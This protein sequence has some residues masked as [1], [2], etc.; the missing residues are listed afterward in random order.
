MIWND[1]EVRAALGMGAGRPDIQFT[2][3]STDSRTV[4]R[5]SLFVA[6]KGER[7]DAHGFVNEV[8][9]KGAR[10]AVVQH[11]VAGLGDDF[12]F[13]VV[14]DTLTALGMLGRHRR[15]KLNA[16]LVAVLGSNGKTTTKEILRALLSARYRVHA[17]TGNLNNLIGTPLTLLAAPDDTEVIVAELGTSLPGEVARL[18]EIVEANAAVVTAISQE[19]LEGLGDL[20]G[21]LEEETALLPSLPQDGLAVV[22]DEPPELATAARAKA[23]RVA[24]AGWSD[25]ADADLRAE[26]VDLDAHGHVMFAWQG[27]NVFLPLR[28]KHN[29]RNA[30]VALGIALH[31]G[32]DVNAA[33][34]NLSELKPA[35]M[36]G[37]VREYGNLKVIVDC[38]NSNPASLSAAIDLLASM[39]HQG[40]RVAI[41]G[42]MLEL[43]GES[44]DLHH[45]AADEIAARNFDLVVAT[46]EFVRA[47][48]PH[49]SR[50]GDRLITSVDPLAAAQQVTQRLQGDEL[51]LLKGSRG[52]A[53]E[54][55]LP[56]L[57]LSGVPHPHGEAERPGAR[58][59]R[60]DSRDEAQSAGH[61]RSSTYEARGRVGEWGTRR[62][63]EPLAQACHDE[64]AR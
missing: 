12:V 6:L 63:E 38:Y 21:V 3:I 37:E 15:R 4:E 17:T 57:E 7:F 30:L 28:G 43:G 54:R 8:A 56:A 23:P 60:T 13:Y 64:G 46:G 48:E 19:H 27:R 5:G 14:P 36:R 18:A 25:R 22:A 55:L 47:F 61:S 53:L 41:V 59:P 11:P 20:R 31:F 50:L 29:A 45:T 39:P 44:A 16:R 52:V 42:S 10:G 33:L 58:S 35:K 49:V 32:V 2:G 34:A 51:V 62:Y 1:A 40:R 24:V 9:A 26:R